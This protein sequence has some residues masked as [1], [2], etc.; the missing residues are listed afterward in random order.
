MPNKKL[1]LIIL[2]NRN[3]KK[4]LEDIRIQSYK[5]DM[6]I[7]GLYKEEK[8]NEILEIKNIYP[9]IKFILYKKN[10]FKALNDL[11]IIQGE[12]VSILNSEDEVTIDFYRTMINEA[13]KNDADVIISNAILKYSDGGKAYLNLSESSLIESEDENNLENY[14][15]QSEVSF[16]WNIYGNKVFS[17]AL[18]DFTVKKIAHIEDEVQNLYFFSLIFYNSKKVKKIDNEVLFYNFEQEN[19]EGIRNFLNNYRII[20]DKLYKNMRKNFEYIEAFFT[21]KTIKININNL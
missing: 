2:L 16:L 19:G 6:E 5:K 8:K 10:F 12:Y 9:E 17:K 13:D 21:E 15:K 4:C 18:Y 3:V 7:I 14:I 11:N 1:S 20:D